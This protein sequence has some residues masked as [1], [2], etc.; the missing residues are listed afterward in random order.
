MAAEIH[1]KDPDSLPSALTQSRQAFDVWLSLTGVSY[2]KV[3]CRETLQ[4]EIAGKRYFIKKHLGVGWLEIFKNLLMLKK[5]VLG[6]RNEWLA[7]ER[8]NAIGIATT[9]LIA[10]GARGCN[11]ARQQS[12]VVT[13]DLG[14]IVTLEDLCKLWSLQPPA[15]AFKRQLILSVAQ[16][17]RTFH[18][19]GM[20]HRDF[21]LCHFALRNEALAR[22][23][24]QLHLMDLHRVEIHRELPD[25][26]RM[27]DLAGLYFSA[28]HIG[29]T[30]RDLLRF[31][32]G[33]MAQPLRKTVQDAAFLQAIAQRAQRLDIKLQR[34]IK[35]GIAL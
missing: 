16:L 21:Y 14:D 33:Y 2:R 25:S 34:K 11:P 13:Q 26:K 23:D 27:K 31:L 24:W 22:G 20:W 18:A 35:A 30:K 10:Y 29:L 3:A 8:L 28:L 17:A 19:H 4:V 1:F 9:P 15:P 5:P 32:K 12:F 6:A 7:I